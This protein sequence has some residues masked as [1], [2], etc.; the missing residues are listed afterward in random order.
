MNNKPTTISI[1]CNNV[2]RSNH[3]TH[4]I[5]QTQAHPDSK[6]DIIIITEPWI[7]TVRAETQ[8]KGTVHHLDWQC[9]P[10][11][12]IQRADV[13]IYI[14]K[15]SPL[16]VHPLTHSEIANES[17]VPIQVS[18]G[19]E[20]SVTIVG[21]YNSPTT[22]LAVHHL[23]NT[24]LP[25]GP[26]ILCGDFNLHAPEW[27]STVLNANALTQQF[28]EWLMD[29]NLQVLNDPDQP[30]YHGHRFQHA[31]VDD[32][33][34]ANLDTF[35]NSDIS[36]IHVLE[37][38]HYSSDHYPIS[39]EI[40]SITNTPI[41]KQRLNLHENHRE[42]WESTIKPI[43]TQIHSQLTPNVSPDSLDKLSQDI[44]EAIKTATHKTMST[45][46]KQS[47]HA[48]HWWNE[49]LDKTI[50]QL[51]RLSTVIRTSPN[52]YL[53]RQ[54][55]RTK[56]VFRAKVRHHKRNWATSR[57]EGANSK[58]V[59]EFTKWYKCRGRRSRPL[60]SSPS[61]VP[62]AT[63]QERALIFAGLFFPAPHPIRGFQAN[64]DPI[65]QRPQAKLNKEEL[66]T[67]ILNVS[68]DTAPGPSEINYTAIRWT[69]ETAPET[70]FFLFS[71]CIEIGHY[72]NPFKHSN[73]LV[74]PKPGKNDYSN[75]SAYRPI[76]LIECLGKVLDKVVA[77]CI[78]YEVAQ[79]NLVPHSQFG[80]RIA[81]STI[82]AGLTLTQDIH[83]AWSKG[84]KASALFY[85]ISGFFN[86]VNHQGLTARLQHLGFNQATVK[87]INAFL[88]GRTT[89]ITFDGFT[90]EP[91]PIQNGIPQGSPL[92]PILAIIY[93][94]ES[95][96]LRSLITRGVYSYAYID[97]GVILTSSPTLDTN[98]T[99]LTQAVEILSNW[100]TENGL[101]AQPS[102]FEL[103][104]FTKGPDPSSPP[105][106]IPNHPPIVAPKHVRWLGFQ[107]DHHLNF[108]Q[109]SKVMASRTIATARAM[110]ILGNTVRGMSHV[111]LRQLTMTTIIPALTYGCQLWWGGRFSK[112]NTARLQ[113]AL[114]QAMRL[115][116]RAFRTT[117][118]QALQ[119]ISHIPPLE[120]TIKKLCYSSSIRLH[121]LL[122]ES[123]VV[124]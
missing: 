62:A 30:T 49:D 122:P 118:V 110:G 12:N 22:H 70:L 51:R 61:N 64:N 29:H 45:W 79:G 28:Q 60:Y 103:M 36:P 117:S 37:D 17:V 95:Q 75:P 114:N 54:Y 18:M 24:H 97:D 2:H 83:K 123:A 107:L 88:V 48:K 5:L 7:G 1:F 74:V 6:T 102:K 46:S 93:S 38:S 55:K 65:P 90:S 42:E 108:I 85:D 59:W 39:F 21:V 76:Q 80:G 121:R 20:F 52:P 84:L 115:I 50:T 105:L 26:T 16:R 72:P 98:V 73:T 19:E 15:T 33:V 14:R 56:D 67:A 91:L 53:I 34:I 44:I 124:N 89:R 96:K 77:R 69:W 66:Q 86:A 23:I 13:T 92:S 10:P 81:S 41:P 101:E 27:D 112:S 87:M 47:I 3:I 68:K 9:I 71:K 11:Q 106:R 119:H 113:R 111:Q 116:C 31:K 82:D 109:Q 43:L 35:E 78:Q 4:A 100:L 58:D 57:L 120:F 99:K 104:H 40:H 25:E 8:E 94:A 32:L 63:D